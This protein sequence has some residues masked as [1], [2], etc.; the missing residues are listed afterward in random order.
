MIKFTTFHE[1]E[2]DAMEKE[3]AGK[4]N[5]LRGASPASECHPLIWERT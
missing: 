3:I 4:V 1:T 5:R 2:E